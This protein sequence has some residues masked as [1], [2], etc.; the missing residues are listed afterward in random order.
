SCLQ[1][2]FQNGRVSKFDQSFARR[3]ILYQIVPGNIELVCPRECAMPD[4]N[5]SSNDIQNSISNKNN[6]NC[7]PGVTTDG[8]DGRRE[9]RGRGRGV[10][11]RRAWQSGLATPACRLAA[12]HRNNRLTDLT[13]AFDNYKETFKVHKLVLGMSSPV[14]ERVLFP[15]GFSNKQHGQNFNLQDGILTCHQGT[16]VAY[17]WVLEHIYTGRTALSTLE[18]ALEVYCLAH[19]LRMDDLFL[20][21]S[22][23]LGGIVNAVNLPLVYNIAVQLQDDRL[24]YQCSQVVT[25][26]EDVIWLSPAVQELNH[27]AL[28]DLLQ[29][30]PPTTTLTV[31]FRALTQW[32][33]KS[34]E[35]QNILVTPNSLREEI[36]DFLPHICGTMTLEDFVNEVV[37]TNIFTMEQCNEILMNMA[38][39]EVQLIHNIDH[40]LPNDHRKTSLE[41]PTYQRMQS[42]SKSLTPPREV[43][44]RTNL[45]R[46]RSPKSIMKEPKSKSQ[47]SLTQSPHNLQNTSHKK[48][49]VVPEN[50]KHCRSRSF[51][52]MSNY[53]MKQITYNEESNIPKINVL[54]PTPVPSPI[55]PKTVCKENNVHDNLLKTCKL[56]LSTNI[57]PN[58][59]GSLS[60]D[61]SSSYVLISNLKTDCQMKLYS[62]VFHNGPPVS[63]DSILTISHD[64][65]EVIQT[66]QLVRSAAGLEARFSM[67]VSLEVHAVY[68]MTVKGIPAG[69]YY[70]TKFVTLKSRK[71]PLCQAIIHTWITDVTLHYQE[72]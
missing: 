5:D 30:Q 52:G 56:E 20:S 4:S 29:Q 36:K 43:T 71:P 17:R 67:P 18:E 42:R 31:L 25:S 32:C 3:S 61:S 21:C 47:L 69:V 62:L 6:F 39:S 60:V 45:S 49:S 13:I 65:K 38:H 54:P 34:L 44:T 22:Q 37:P 66:T 12:L 53:E 48:Q 55:P 19:H 57:V 35:V 70:D 59:E 50:I 28:L 2:A 68:Y 58:V 26:G 27:D 51:D 24:L 23:C 33:Q 46:S 14:F 40:G 9:Q 72:Y 64:S 15:S 1:T 8:R 41:V 10:R 16:P 11:A 7:G 63:K